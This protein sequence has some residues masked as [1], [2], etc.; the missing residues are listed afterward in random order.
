MIRV[1]A[2][3]KETGNVPAA[4]LSGGT[5]NVRRAATTFL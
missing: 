4:R 5:A 2:A 3:R 1:V